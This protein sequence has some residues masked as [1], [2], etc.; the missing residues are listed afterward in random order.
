MV[1]DKMREVLEHLLKIMVI[2]EEWNLMPAL[3]PEG[4]GGDPVYID[5]RC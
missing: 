5:Q 1:H 4:G 2:N 3:L